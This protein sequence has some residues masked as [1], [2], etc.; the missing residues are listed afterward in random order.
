MEALSRRLVRLSNNILE[1]TKVTAMLWEDNLRKRNLTARLSVV[2]VALFCGSKLRWEWKIVLYVLSDYFC[3]N[4]I[5]T[6]LENTKETVNIWSNFNEWNVSSSV[7]AASQLCHI[8][9][10][11]LRELKNPHLNSFKDFNSRFYFKAFPGTDLN[12]TLFLETYKN[13]LTILRC[14][15]FVYV[16]ISRNIRNL[17]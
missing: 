11:G 12:T 8:A 13:S 6:Y 10:P 7:I 14:F 1:R 2:E 9:L 3:S 16:R 17:K 4:S 15:A 5:W